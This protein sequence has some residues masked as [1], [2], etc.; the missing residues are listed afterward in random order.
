MA[1]LAV[2]FAIAMAASVVTVWAS[3]SDA[4]WE[5]VATVVSF[6]EGTEVSLL[7]LR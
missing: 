1:T 4:A 5:D 7:R 3:V 2:T 6:D